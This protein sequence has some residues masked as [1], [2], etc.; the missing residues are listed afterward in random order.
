MLKQT[1][2]YTKHLRWLSILLFVVL[3][4]CTRGGPASPTAPAATPT[5]SGP[6]ATP[7]PT[8]T[9]PLPTATPEPLAALINETGISLAEYQAELALYQAAVARELTPEDKQRV[10]DNMIDETLLALAADGRGFALDETAIEERMR[11]LSD[12]LGGEAALSEWITSHGHT[13]ETFRRALLRAAAAA[14]MR[15]QILVAVPKITEQV[16]ARQV[17]LYNAEEANDVFA[18]LQAGND[19]GNLAVK[20]DP[21]IAGDLGW[22]PRGYLPD[23]KIEQAAFSLEPGKY[24]EVIETLAGFHILQVIE[25]DQQ[26]P[27]DPGALLVLQARALEDWLAERRAQSDIQILVPLS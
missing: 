12:Q 17:L 22:F 6:T 2:F 1:L 20:Y 3:A 21:I 13:P 18:Q 11:N 8:A 19:F 25:H 9:P 7:S 26:R 16:H 14:W 15:D 10:L 23:A 27:L 24:S 5:L 4:A